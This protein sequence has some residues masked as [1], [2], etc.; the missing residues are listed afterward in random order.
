MSFALFLFEVNDPAQVVSLLKV[1]P[2][3]G[4]PTLTG[5]DSWLLLVTKVT[6]G[7]VD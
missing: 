6:G 3:S 7:P 1:A 2:S 5:T 4:L